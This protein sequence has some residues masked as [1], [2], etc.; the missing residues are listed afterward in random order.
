MASIVVQL[1]GE[2]GL[3]IVADRLEAAVL[4]DVCELTGELHHLGGE[5]GDLGDV[6]FHNL[7]VLFIQIVRLRR[8]SETLSQSSAHLH[9]QVQRSFDY[10]AEHADL[11]L[12]QEISVLDV[13]LTQLFQAQHQA[14]HQQLHSL[15]LLDSNSFLRFR[16]KRH[17]KC[18][19][20]KLHIQR[21]SDSNQH[22][23][24]RFHSMLTDL[25]MELEAHVL[26]NDCR[27]WFNIGCKRRAHFL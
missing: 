20:E 10:R 9:H 3:R 13:L 8:L 2:E 7:E 11:S 12:G 18:L 14:F 15:G 21:L 19:L 22:I 26:H 17:F 6:I 1:R 27:E 23:G 16:N 24:K 25:M 4:E 5:L